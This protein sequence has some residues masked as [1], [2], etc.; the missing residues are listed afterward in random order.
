MVVAR[1]RYLLLHPHVPQPDGTM[2]CELLTGHPT[3]QPT[4]WCSSPT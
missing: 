1:P 4:S 3:G 2:L